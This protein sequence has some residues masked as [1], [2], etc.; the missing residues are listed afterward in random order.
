MKGEELRQAVRALLKSHPDIAVSSAGHAT[1]A[2]RYETKSGLPIGFEP[3]RIRFQNLWVRANSVRRHML[4]DIEQVYY[5]HGDFGH[6]KPNHN[7]FCEGAFSDSDD[8]IRFQVTDLWQAVRV[9]REVAGDGS[10]S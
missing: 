3:E 7:L 4:K 1:H 2:E 8:L 10:K 9:I 6:S 5:D